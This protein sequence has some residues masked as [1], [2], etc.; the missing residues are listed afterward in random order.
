M[1]KIWKEIVKNEQAMAIMMILIQMAHIS[2]IG[3]KL[4]KKMEDKK[5]E[6]RVER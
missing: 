5:T 6:E 1:L 4:N 3:R 2:P